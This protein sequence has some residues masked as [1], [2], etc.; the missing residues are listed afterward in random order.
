MLAEQPSL[1]SLRWR[2]CFVAIA[3]AASIALGYA[4]VRNNWL[5]LYAHNWIIWSLSVFVVHL[6]I[7]WWGLKHNYRRHEEKLLPT[8][9]YGN[10]LTLTRGLVICLLAG[11]LFAPRPTGLLAWAPALL[12]TVACLL[13]YL[14]GYVARI[15]GHATV[16]GEIL[17][18]EFDGLGMLIAV[19][20]AIQYGQ[21]PPWYLVLG[22]ARQLFVFGMWVRGR[23]DLPVYELPPSDN[24]RLIAGFQMGFMTVM[25][26]PILAPPI[27]TLASLL[28]AVPL[29]LSFGRDWLVVSGW[30]DADAPN[31]Q[32][33]RFGVKRWSEQR[34]PLL[35]RVV[36]FVVVLFLFFGAPS[37]TAAWRAYVS[38]AAIAP[39]A[40]LFGAMALL[41]PVAALLFLL[42]IGARGAAVVLMST[43]LLDMLATGFAW[44]TNALLL[45]CT[46]WVL[47]AGSGALSLWAIEEKLL[48][49]RLGEPLAN[50]SARDASGDAS[51]GASK[52]GAQGGSRPPADDS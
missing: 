41:S 21:I 22:V 45:V 42:G 4:I 6:G 49:R 10:G 7:L 35:L 28:F 25:L 46:L 2:W 13:D 31:Y 18:M 24:R 34:I 30:F 44:Q 38:E 14:D 19:T 8:L 16:L 48:R 33:M 15:T 37:H 5:P 40:L 11:F 1:S 27:T 17:D 47:Q 20:L 32:R 43:A 29:A 26:W 51:E 3:Y 23:L 39:L 12:Y 36:G 52:D 9:G 50:E